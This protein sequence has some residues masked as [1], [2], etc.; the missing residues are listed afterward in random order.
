MVAISISFCCF[1]LFDAKLSFCGGRR[2]VLCLSGI[3]W[4][5]YGDKRD[6]KTTGNNSGGQFFPV[7]I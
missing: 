5:R 6:T 4:R 1:Y 7:K 2:I 3:L